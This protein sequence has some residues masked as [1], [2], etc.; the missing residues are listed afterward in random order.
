MAERWAEARLD[1]VCTLIT[2]GTH[3]SPP[4][5]KRG[6]FRYVTAKNIRPWGLDLTDITWVSKDV[7]EE[8]FARC[9]VE[10][11]DVLYIKDGV[12]T[13]LAAINH[14]KEP[15]SLLSSVALL[16][17]DRRILYPA[18]LKHW[19]NSPEIFARMTADM[20]G[21]AIRR[22]VLR[23]IRSALILLPSLNEQKRIADKLDAIL[24][25]VDA[26]RERLDRMPAI[27]KRFHQAV[28]AAATS[29]KLTED[30]REE[31]AQ[32]DEWPQVE[33]SD[34]ARD[35]SYGSAAKSSRSG[36]IPVLRMGNI[37][38]GRLDWSDL[39]YTSDPKEISKYRL[40]PGDVLFNRTNSPELVGKT[41]VYQ[42]E[43]NAIYAG[44]LIRIR[45]TDR[46]LPDYLSYCL[47]S[48]AGRDYCWQVKSDGV[49]Q[50]NIN[51]KKLAAFEFG[52]P[53]IEEQHEIVDRVKDLFAYADRLEARYTAAHG[54]IER[55]TPTLLAKAFRGEL[56][57]QDPNDEP[58]SV[59]L[60]R[61]RA[62]R[63]AVRQTAVPN[64]RKG[65]RPK[66]SRKVEVLMLTRKD[67]EST[68]LTK[69][70]TERGPLTAEALWSASQLDIDDFY[71][72]LKDE[73]A[74]GLLREKRGDS[75][76][77]PRT[78]EAA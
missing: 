70:L 68:H 42:G 72:Q 64:R 39:V 36:S 35:F 24:V 44:Y 21:S 46:L 3:H 10:I 58:A 62:E 17:P 73:E 30:W 37:Q 1:E 34:A 57:P 76:N 15:F 4:N 40:A 60:E 19:L 69:I 28:L 71:E 66:T 31:N 8:I 38:D 27:L 65:S 2:D 47:N 26:C 54:R 43:R 41:A 51:A 7:H 20:T 22:L 16:K 53:G 49:S 48:P 75:S 29:G 9:P 78:L 12:T 11:G 59:L 25:R 18:F 13:G 6:D 63:E 77:A 52:L 5:S 67:I 50:S 45:C 33:L 23:Q 32:N 56:V 61:I 55:L 74:R 14:L